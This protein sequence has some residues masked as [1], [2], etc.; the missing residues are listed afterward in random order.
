MEKFLR[1]AEMSGSVSIGHLS[2][3]V[4]LCASLLDCILG[5]TC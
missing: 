5:T 1:D 3:C 2:I 4:S